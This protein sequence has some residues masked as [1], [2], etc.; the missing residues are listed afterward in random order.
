MPGPDPDPD[1]DPGS[2]PDQ[3][4]GP[5]LFCEPITYG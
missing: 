2:G 5:V 4:P 1:P 3:I